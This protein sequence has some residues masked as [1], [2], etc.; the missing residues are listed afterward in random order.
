MKKLGILLLLFAFLSISCSKA[1]KLQDTKIWKAPIFMMGETSEF[2][3]QFEE[4][5]LYFIIEDN[6]DG[7]PNKNEEDVLKIYK[8]VPET[9]EVYG[10]IIA[11]PLDAE[12]MDYYLILYFKN[13][14]EDKVEILNPL[15]LM[16]SFVESPDAPKTVEEAKAYIPSE[17]EKSQMLFQTFYNES[18]FKE[19]SAKPL[20]P[21][22]DKEAFLKILDKSIEY[23]LNSEPKPEGMMFGFTMGNLFAKA[24]IESNYSISPESLQNFQDTGDKLDENKDPDFVERIEKLKATI[25]K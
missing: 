7:T 20:F 1:Q 5:K 24:L 11:R 22:G 23:I 16:M 10:K 8:I 18:A 3:Y 17:E 12:G 9:E 2:M 4:D 25:E 6:E 13:L 19:L 14:E 15:S 21:K